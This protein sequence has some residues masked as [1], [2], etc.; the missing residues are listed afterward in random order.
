MSLNHWDFAFNNAELY[1][2][3]FSLERPP[4]TEETVTHLRALEDV[5]F[6]F[7][8]N[9][10]VKRELILHWMCLINGA[11]SIVMKMSH[12]PH[13]EGINPRDIYIRMIDRFIDSL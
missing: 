8:P 6:E 9:E 12:F 3:M 1:Q 4:L 10:G 7:A 2:L 5:F 13:H 11:V